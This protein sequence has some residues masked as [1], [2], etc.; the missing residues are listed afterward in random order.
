MPPALGIYVQFQ[1]FKERKV[2]HALR[3]HADDY[4]TSYSYPQL[5][6]CSMYMIR[7]VGKTRTCANGDM[8]KVSQL[9]GI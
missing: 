6:R 5:F 9:V 2:L 7:N 1:L 3:K 8:R 4:K